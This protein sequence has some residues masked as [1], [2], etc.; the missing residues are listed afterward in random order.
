MWGM[1]AAPSIAPTPALVRP[2]AISPDSGEALPLET[3]AA[4]LLARP[5]CRRIQI[6]GGPGSGKTTA[7]RHLAATLPFL[8]QAAL[9]DEPS[10]AE[11]SLQAERQPVIFAS[12]RAK[13]A[14]A[15][16]ELAGWTT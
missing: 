12:R 11:V 2:R 3:L 9:L 10:A 5:D 7:L 4:E 16:L 1:S 6:A 8:P 15:V 13:E 14:D